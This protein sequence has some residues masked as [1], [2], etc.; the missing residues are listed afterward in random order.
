MKGRGTRKAHE[1]QPKGKDRG[2]TRKRKEKKRLPTP[3]KY[4]AYSGGGA[5]MGEVAGVGG[6]VNKESLDGKP[7]VD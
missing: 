3:P 7:A 6:E 5:S 2:L 1:R 4:I